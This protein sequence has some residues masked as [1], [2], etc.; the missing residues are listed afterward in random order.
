MYAR[1]AAPTIDRLLEHRVIALFGKGG[2]GRTS[3]A[4]GLASLAAGRGHRTLVMETDPRAPLAAAHQ[5][6]PSF[7]PRQAAANIWTMLLD[8][9]QSLEEYLGFIVN[10]SILRAVFASSLYQYF[11]HAAPAVRELMMM[12]KIYHEIERRPAQEPPWDLIVVDLPASGQALGMIA[13]PFAAR[14]T[15]GNNLVGREAEQVGHFFQDRAKFAIA[16]VTSVD[17]LAMTETL[18]IHRKLD[19]LGLTIAAVV[20]NRM[21]PATFTAA[22]V[23]HAFA[24]E[25]ATA[26]QADFAA[27]AQADLKRRTRERRALGLLKRAVGAP[28][29]HLS[30]CQGRCG[31][32]LATSLAEQLASG[33]SR[34]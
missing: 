6:S 8:R 29:I 14:E 23:A 2:V 24:S 21:S 33:G 25:V 7:R 30:E 16:I 26:H 27:L 28:V 31:A 9:Q 32:A 19:V 22:D 10:R 4:A 5:Q 1:E 15:F 17:Q 11:V 20:F 18:E 3:V 13:M 12:G 34:N